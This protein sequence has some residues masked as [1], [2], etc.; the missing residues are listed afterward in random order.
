MLFILFLG[1]S[2]TGCS[3]TPREAP[4]PTGKPVV[5]ETSDTL[6]NP[7]GQSSEPVQAEALDEPKQLLLAHGDV[8]F[9]VPKGWRKMPV[10][11]NIPE[12]ELQLPRTEGDTFDGRLTLMSSLG[13]HE[14]NVARWKAEFT[15]AGEPK[16][17]KLMLGGVEATMVDIR[18]EWKGSARPIPPRPDYRLIAV[19]IPLAGGSAYYMKLTGPKATLAA[20]DEEIMSFLKSVKIK[21]QK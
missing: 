7:H 20:R 4:V 13:T 15:Q 5:E 6:K 3:E 14:E 17:D 18:G 9:T 8:I 2:L 21:P 10:D 11:G 19:S 16:V 12:A 1:V